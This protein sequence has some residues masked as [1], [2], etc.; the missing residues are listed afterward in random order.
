MTIVENPPSNSAAFVKAE[1]DRLQ[2]EFESSGDA[3]TFHSG[4]SS[5]I[6]LAVQHRYKEHLE[7]AFASGLALLAVG[8]YGRQELFP[9][10]DVDLLLLVAATPEGSRKEAVA[11]FL[12]SLWDAG[13]RL[14]QSVH[15]VAEC[16]EMHGGNIELNASL[17]D[18]RFLIGDQ[19]L[20]QD[21]ST[22]F[23]KFL[24][25]QR[26]SLAR[27]L[28]K[29]AHERHAKFHDTIYHLEP[30]LK[31]APGGLRD[32]HLL[33][34]LNHLFDATASGWQRELSESRAFV[35]ALRTFL[36]LRSGRDNNLVSFDVQEE[37]PAQSYL[38]C[39][40]PA[41]FMREYF[42]NARAIHRAAVRA[43]ESV[44]EKGN[45]LLAG[46][47]DW[48][49]RLSNADFTVSRDRILFKSPHHL[50]AD[51][52]LPLRLGEFIARHKVSLHAEAERRIQQHL[53]AIRDHLEHPRS[54]WP[55]VRAMLNQP[56]AA[57]GL[58]ALHDSGILGALFPEWD[59]IYCYVIRDFH[60]R[61]TVDEHTLIA[62]ESLEELA[63]TKDPSHRRFAGLLSEIED[64]S[65]LRL[66]LLF[67]DVSK[68]EESERHCLESAT[69]ADQAAARISIPPHERQMLR[70][71]IER[72]LDLS[73]AMTSRDLEDPATAR[74]LA[75]RVGTVEVLK[76]LTLLT[77]ADIGAVHPSALSPWRLDQL[78]R[79][80]VVSH[81]EL[82]RELV[83]DKIAE[84]SAS[85]G[86]AEVQAF[87]KGFP[88]R[89]LRIHTE[90]EIRAHFDLEKARQQYGVAL[91]I[92]KQEAVYHLTVLAKD[93]HYLFASVAGA[94]AGFGMNIVK[95]EA[96]ANQQGTILDTFAFT[97][98]KRTLELNP[99][100]LDRLRQTIERVLLG[101]IDVKALL[102][103]RPKPSPPTRSSR[104]QGRI[105][106][107]TEASDAAT[108]VE[109]V[110]EDRP[111]LLYDLASAFSEAGCSIEVV[112]VDTEAHKA[113]DVFYVTAHGRKLTAD[114]QARLRGE[115][116][117]VVV[118]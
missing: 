37:A 51:P 2:R 80:Y 7:P 31:E 27:Q 81:Q 56:N 111:G 70:S 15:N 20:Q 88:T 75:D 82:T 61:Y 11:R 25:S 67:H 22:R 6:D 30:N 72:H 64:L 101:R 99:T 105:N 33:G 12:Q 114:L 5:L 76:N 104:I 41:G 8:G 34:W 45:S 73:S 38:R 69:M 78:W 112:L 90:E 23:P 26:T 55:L 85:K 57:A 52:N 117:Q 18:Q 107:D 16:C 53:P 39:N 1:T 115:L 89:Y 4:R 24:H 44:E 106:F 21:L 46:F 98:P 50:E 65:I 109:V 94:L 102:K 71:L 118:Q 40:S 14:S 9:H 116:Q 42:R 63:R 97:D 110:A 48:R 36:H 17:L 68:G 32:L 19:R 49:S 58:R 62:I 83:T 43:M 87:L 28:C 86:P 59:S 96:F 74:W 84:G 66:A 35:A 92:R 91:E 93:R 13:F 95:A 77:Y 79:V 29:L 108:L 113:M 100:E 10:S 54:I 47:R 3:A 60:H 103:N